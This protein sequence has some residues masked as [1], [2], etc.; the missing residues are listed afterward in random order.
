MGKDLDLDDVAAQSSSAVLELAQLRVSLAAA[1]AA[2][3][4]MRQ[5]IE[6]VSDWHVQPYAGA[7]SECFF[8]GSSV[9][10][11]AECIS[12]EAMAIL[13][14]LAPSAPSEAK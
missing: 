5:I 3:E 2:I 6:T 8:C 9:G 14:A 7:N 1:R 13:A 12:S 4:R 10:H 11:K